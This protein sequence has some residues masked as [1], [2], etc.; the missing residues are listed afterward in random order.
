MTRSITP[1]RWS[2]V[3]G[4]AL[5]ALGGCS[6][7]GGEAPAPDLG[8]VAKPTPPKKKKPALDPALAD[9]PIDTARPDDPAR[10]PKQPAEPPSQVAVQVVLVKYRGARKAKGVN[11]S[12]AEAERRA[13][14]IVALAR[15][16]GADFAALARKISEQPEEERGQVQVI[17]P[18]DRPK[19]FERFAFGMGVGQVSDPA[20]TKLGY[21]VIRRVEAQEYASAHILIQYK[22]AMRAPIALTRSKEDARKLAE[23][24]QA[25]A[26]KEGAEFAVLAARS[27]ES[28]TK[29]SGGVIRPMA[30]GSM[31]P[32]YTAYI[33]ALRKLEVGAVSPV[34]ETP[35]GFHII[36]RIKLEYITA[37]HILIS[38]TGAEEGTPRKERSK[39]EA[40]E[41]ARKLAKEAKAKGADFA[42]LA[43]EN[44]D[45]AHTADKGGQLPRFARGMMPFWR[46]ERAAFALRPGQISDPVETP[47]GFHIILRNE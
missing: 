14:R 9:L 3:L 39:R 31:P 44:S 37:S 4:G 8:G 30:P 36:K 1:A 45:D 18:G 20:K 21:F 2:V 38:F 11:R 16:K 26:S 33:D 40:Q 10:W 5:I 32:E 19:P 7:K 34:V 29:V 17:S 46:F 47:L 24:V 23:K 15:Q 12:E 35:F 25:L 42:A 27:S 13:R 6:S 41:L 22:G 43:R 28:P